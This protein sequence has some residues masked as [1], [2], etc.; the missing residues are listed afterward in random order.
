MFLLVLFFIETGHNQD[1]HWILVSHF[2]GKVGEECII[3]KQYCLAC[4]NGTLVKAQE[5]T[6]VVSAGEAF[7]MSMLIEREWVK[8]L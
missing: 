4:L 5:W 7:I 3:E 8:E 2:K 1:L 6:K